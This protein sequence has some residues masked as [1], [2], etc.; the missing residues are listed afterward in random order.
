MLSRNSQ[1]NLWDWVR[2]FISKI[3]GKEV[4]LGG[5][6]LKFLLLDTFKTSFL[7]ENLFLMETISIRSGQG[8]PVPSSGASVSVSEHALI[9]LNMPKYR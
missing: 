3:H 4:I 8:F 9:S 2:D 1:E 6:I 5:S 7:M